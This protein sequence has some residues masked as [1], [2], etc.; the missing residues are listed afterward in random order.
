M[1]LHPKMYSAE[2]IKEIFDCLSKTGLGYDPGIS[3][4]NVVGLR[5]GER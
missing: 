3:Q 1:E 2:T 4:G 5:R